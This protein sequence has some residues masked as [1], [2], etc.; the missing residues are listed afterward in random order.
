MAL[1]HSSSPHRSPRSPP[2]IGTA[3][4]TF[5]PPTIFRHHGRFARRCAS[6]VASPITAAPF[7]R[8]N[9]ADGW[10]LPPIHRIRETAN[11]L[12]GTRFCDLKR[13]GAKE[14][15]APRHSLMSIELQRTTCRSCSSMPFMPLLADRGLDPKQQ[16]GPRPLARCIGA[17][18]T[19]Q[20]LR[21]RAPPT[22]I[23]EKSWSG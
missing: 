16:D 1:F 15:A 2:G 21:W 6:S 20:T 7:H 12:C 8:L 5:Y 9:V 22:L 14:C 13:R 17:P 3:T 19:L 10:E 23:E 18:P 11:S 4:H